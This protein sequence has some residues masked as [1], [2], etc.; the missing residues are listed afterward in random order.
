MFTSLSAGSG[1]PSPPLVG[2]AWFSFFQE[3]RR[4]SSTAQHTRCLTRRGSSIGRCGCSNRATWRPKQPKTASNKGL[5]PPSVCTTLQITG[6]KASETALLSS[7]LPQIISSG[8]RVQAPEIPGRAKHSSLRQLP[9]PPSS[10]AEN[11][12]LYFEIHF[13]GCYY[14]PCNE[15]LASLLF[16]ASPALVRLSRVAT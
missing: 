13:S 2:I 4:P 7:L 3:S 14:T 5:R 1:H 10:R 11:Y 12:T 9:V 15:P 16:H 8:P 6:L